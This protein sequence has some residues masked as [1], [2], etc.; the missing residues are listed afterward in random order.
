MRNFLIFI[1]FFIT[2]CASIKYPHSYFSDCEKNFNKFSNLYSCALKEIEKNCKNKSNCKVEE[3]RFVD[4]MKRLQI[5]VDN[6]EISENEAMLRY[7]NII[8]L[9]ELKFRRTN[10]IY[11]SNYHYFL[12]NSILRGMSSYKIYNGIYY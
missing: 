8:D 11:T 9:E 4:I 10:N 12:N 3:N 2:S 5:M 1:L 6:E 7:F